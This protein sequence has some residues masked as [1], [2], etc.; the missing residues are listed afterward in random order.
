MNK[1]YT[2]IKSYEHSKIEFALLLLSW[3]IKNIILKKA[4]RKY[5][6]LNFSL[7][8]GRIFMYQIIDIQHYNDCICAP[9]VKKIRT[10]HSKRCGPGLNFFP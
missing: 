3:S 7:T 4:D 9:H 6:R 5:L 10:R 2:I 8:F 1:L